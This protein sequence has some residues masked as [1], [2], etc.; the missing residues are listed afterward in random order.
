VIWATTMMMSPTRTGDH[1]TLLKKIKANVA[2]PSD[3]DTATFSSHS[4]HA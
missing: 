4:D 3:D 1:I 2:A